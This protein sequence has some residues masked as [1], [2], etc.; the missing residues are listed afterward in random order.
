VAPASATAGSLFAHVYV[1]A[2]PLE[3]RRDSMDNPSNF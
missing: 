1:E 2:R 3:S